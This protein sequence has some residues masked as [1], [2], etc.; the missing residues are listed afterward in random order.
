MLDLA[1]MPQRCFDAANLRAISSNTLSEFFKDKKIAAEVEDDQKAILA[2]FDGLEHYGG[3]NQGDRRALFYLIMALEP[4]KVLEVGTHIGA[5]T[6]YIARALRKL[7]SGGTMT[8]V[9]ILDVN[10][11]E[12]APWK[13]IGL[14]RPPQEF[15]VCLECA[16]RITFHTGT[17]LD[18]MS[19][20]DQKFDLIFLDG[21][22]SACAV[23][24]EVN[25][26]L[27]ILAPGGTL[28]LHDYYPDGKPLYPDG[29]AITGP[30]QALERIK[31]ENP[32]IGVLPLG[33][34]PWPTKQGTNITSLALVI[35]A[36]D[37]ES[38][39]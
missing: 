36:Q 21:D 15:A 20:S 39:N 29:A 3:V 26:A 6:L 5:S 7:G 14:T 10:N 37:N 8:S 33:S 1:A 22:H 18:F 13:E 35:R 25:A 31:K 24:Q 17:S 19:N 2:L 9:D 34:L 16:D 27:T 12:E 30:Y 38:K 32:A 11:A 28:L 23:Y 4:L